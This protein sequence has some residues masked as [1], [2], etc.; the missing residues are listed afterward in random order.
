MCG[1]YTLI[2]GYLGDNLKITVELCNAAKKN[3]GKINV[4]NGGEIHPNDPAPAVLIENSRICVTSMR[5]GFAKK[6][7][8]LIINARC[9]SASSRAI[10]RDLLIGN[11]CA[12]PA[13]GYFEWRDSDHLKHLILPSDAEGFY[14][15]GLYRMESDGVLHFVVLTREA[16]GAHAGIHKRMPVVLSSKEDVCRWLCGSLSIEALSERMPENLSIRSMGTEQ[17]H[18]DFDDQSEI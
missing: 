7:N 12:L 2:V 18:M 4:E 5:W 3:S 13:A 10:F 1:R 14:L 6:D 16:F 9:E 11:R 17:L 15:A 8:G